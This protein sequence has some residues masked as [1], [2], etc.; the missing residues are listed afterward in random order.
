MVEVIGVFILFAVGIMLLSE[1]RP[2]GAP[3]TVQSM[4]YSCE[5]SDLL[6]CNF[7]SVSGR[8][9]TVPIGSIPYEIKPRTYCREPASLY[10]RI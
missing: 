4:D 1:E 3:D 10:N 8:Y 9:S 6:G 5:Q 2:H 7:C